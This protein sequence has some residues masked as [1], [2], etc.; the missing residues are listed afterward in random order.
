M[1][2]KHVIVMAKGL[3]YQRHYNSCLLKTNAFICS[4][5]SSWSMH[6]YT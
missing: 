4:P 3:F 1:K 5:V 6:M 2:H